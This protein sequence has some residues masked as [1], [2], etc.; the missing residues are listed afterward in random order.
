MRAGGCSLLGLLITRASTDVRF[1][2]S[3]ALETDENFPKVFFAFLT[4]LYT[5]RSARLRDTLAPP[6]HKADRS[7]RK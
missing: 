4:Y 7:P 5:H 2:N 3:E 1:K 6:V